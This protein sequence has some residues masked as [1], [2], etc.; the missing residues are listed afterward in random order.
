MM[1]SLLKK[2]SFKDKK[3][4]IN[5]QKSLKLNFDIKLIESNIMNY[6]T[7]L[8]EKLKDIE[9]Q[10]EELKKNSNQNQVNQN[11]NV[12][13]FLNIPFMNSK[14]TKYELEYIFTKTLR[15]K[16]DIIYLQHYLTNFKTLISGLTQKKLLSDPRQLLGQISKYLKSEHFSNNQIV[17][18]FGERGDKFYMILSGKVAILIP[19]PIKMFMNKTNYLNYLYK[20]LCLKEYGL[21]IKIIDKNFSKFHMF[22]VLDIKSKAEFNTLD[23][24]IL[25]RRSTIKKDI[26]ENQEDK[27]NNNKLN[28]YQLLYSVPSVISV[29]DYINLI[30][31]DNYNDTQVILDEIDNNQNK[32][33]K[34]IV[35]NTNKSINL[36]EENNNEIEE[37]NEIIEIYNYYQV[38]TL[39]NFSTFGDVA[40]SDDTPNRTATIICLNDMNMATLD[41]KIYQ[42]CIKKCQDLIR[43]RN[44]SCVMNLPFFE[45]IS[46]EKFTNNYFN[47]FNQVTTTRGKYL[48]KSKEKREKVFF[49]K[50]GE[51][52]L[53]MHS[54]IINLNNIIE[55]FDK[56]D[57]KSRNKIIH[58]DIYEDDEL[59]IFYNKDNVM[60]FWKILNFKENDVIGLDDCVINN[61]YFLEAKCKSEEVILYEIEYNIFLEMVND[62]KI[63]PLFKKYEKFR[64]DL[65]LKKIKDLR[66]YYILK[67]YKEKDQTKNSYYEKNINK[68]IINNE[69][70][71][72]K[73]KL[74]NKINNNEVNNNI[75]NIIPNKNK[76][77][78]K[79]LSNKNEISPFN[80]N[81]NFYNQLNNYNRLTSSI[82]FENKKMKQIFNS[83]STLNSSPPSLNYKYLIKSSVNIN[84]NKKK[85]NNINNLKSN[86]I[87]NKNLDSHVSN[88]NS[89][90]MIVNEYD[91]K[92]NSRTFSPIEKKIITKKIKLSPN[93]I[94]K[95]NTYFGK[96]SEQIN[97]LNYP[98]FNCINEIIQKLTVNHKK[99]KS[100][101]INNS[102][103]KRY[104]NLIPINNNINHNRT[105]SE[106]EKNKII[107][108]NN[109]NNLYYNNIRLN[110]K[111]K[112]SNLKE[113]ED[114][115]KYIS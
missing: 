62:R 114:L 69:I 38:A 75:I 63:Y 95:F 105:Y 82:K 21:L 65:I 85:F 106:Y 102:M 83:E 59:A 22:E 3:F 61:I 39:H 96:N 6:A 19:S 113:L 41:N 20:L 43:T 52:E 68:S 27:I 109:R 29:S 112:E 67:N 40:L 103:N 98:K 74:R 87:L 108:N 50:Q 104:N 111:I 115:M 37:K 42:K 16:Y 18:R 77:E 55:H 31:P 10:N 46:F 51:I 66:E 88:N 54:N 71:I 91:N 79:I 14:Y 93:C 58:H 97:E 23:K 11:N 84:L 25:K 107:K 49:I 8:E 4:I 100:L 26:N 80:S 101:N 89:Y 110:K 92:F 86:N 15:N 17:F 9:K 28:N 64:I 36:N 94:T 60:N 47:Y 57:L 73:E 7:K 12:K 56:N 2:I 76:Q 48:F 70:I 5:K 33:K 1:N 13:N 53:R 72:N 24:K 44:I 81:P 90:K 32:E 99:N 78:I 34:S 30:L 35:I 45:E